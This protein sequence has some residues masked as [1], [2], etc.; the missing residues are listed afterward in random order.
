MINTIDDFYTEAEKYV[1]EFNAFAE[2]NSLTGISK[3]D[4]ICYKC[5]SK[6]SFEYIRAIFESNS[7][8]IHQ[9][10]ISQRRLAYIKFKRGIETAL[11]P[12]NFLELSDQ[13]PDGSQ[14]NKFD[15]IEVY[16]V[17]ISYDGF[18]KKLEASNKVTKVERPHHTTHDIDMGD[19]FIFRCT[20]EPLIDKIKKSEML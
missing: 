9:S 7:D 3:A 14:Q 11:G 18:I 6:E 1:Q 4:H 16:P 17:T 19:G 10:I 20:T 15:H 2:K 5:D 8:Y 13:K 12:I